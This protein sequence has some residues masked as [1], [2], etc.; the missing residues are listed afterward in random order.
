MSSDAKTRRGGGEVPFWIFIPPYAPFYLPPEIQEKYKVDPSP[1]IES[2]SITG[3]RCDLMCEHCKGHLLQGMTA[4]EDPA[5]LKSHVR[6]KVGEGVKSFLI[7]GGSNREGE[8]DFTG[9]YG[10]FRELVEEDGANILLHSGL[11]TGDTAREL[12]SIGIRG[13]MLDIVGDDA[14]IR[15]VL[16]LDKTVEDYRAALSALERYNVPAIPHVVL[17]LK[18][19][20]MAGEGTALRIVLEHHFEA[21]VFVALVGNPYTG[22]VTYSPGFLAKADELFRTFREE[23]P[24]ATVLLGCAHGQGEVRLG[25]ET[26]AVKHGFTGITYPDESTLLDLDASGTRLEIRATCCGNVKFLAGKFS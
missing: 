11:I 17:G 6:E 23:R 7:S 19:G 5:T 10:A 24:D 14:T 13:V 2:I 20:Q 16:H 4:C 21:L 1:E 25:L 18:G 26:L 8:V 15:E 12:S 3:T 9:F 22:P